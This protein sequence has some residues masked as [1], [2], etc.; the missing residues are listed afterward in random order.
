MEKNINK[1]PMKLQMFA[2]SNIQTKEDFSDADVLSID[3]AQQFNQ[4]LT[5]FY[6]ALGIE[7]LMP[8]SA[9]TLI[10][11]YKAETTLA[12]GEVGEGED[13]P[14]SKVKRTIANTYE[15]AFDKRRKAVPVELIHRV[16]FEKA[17]E[18]TDKKFIREI[19]KKIRDDFF[20]SLD[21]GTGTAT[22]ASF[23]Q[24]SA[25]AWAKVTSAFPEDDVTV[26]AF[27]NPVDVADYLSGVNI[28]TQN[29]FGLTYAENVLGFQT[30]IIHPSIKKGTFYATAS[31]NL[32]LAYAE[33][34]G[35]INKGGFGFVTDDSEIIGVTH[36]VNKINLTS[37]TVTL[38]GITLYAELLDGVVKGT[39]TGV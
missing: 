4:K 21:K 32:V 23:K 30:A 33:I 2:E 27:F 20:K 12:G 34:N 1:F 11:V 13:I 37:Q 35:E 7:R 38:F 28:S 26:I 17:V 16:G 3:F 18:Q 14:L 29:S 24:A 36:D 15:L 6:T 8:M 10:K 25:Q 39:I 9:G 31:Q 5:S 19:Q 22:G